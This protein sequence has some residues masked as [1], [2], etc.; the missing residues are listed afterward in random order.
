[1]KL[2]NNFLFINCLVVSVL[3]IFSVFS[4]YLLNVIGEDTVASMSIAVITILLIA[5]FIVLLRLSKNTD[6]SL[7]KLKQQ[8]DTVTA[9]A[10]AEDFD[11]SHKVSVS[12]F[13]EI[14]TLAQSFNHFTEI[15]EKKTQR[16]TALARES[17]LAQMGL[18]N[19][20][21]PALIVEDNGMVTYLNRSMFEFIQAHSENFQHYQGGF[22]NFPLTELCG[23]DETFVLSMME[24][25]DP[26]LKRVNQGELIINWHVTPVINEQNKIAIHIIEWTDLTEKI[27]IQEGF[28]AL[29]SAAKEGDFSQVMCLEDKTGF[30]FTMADGLNSIMQSVNGSLADVADVLH[31][32]AEGQ[33][34]KTIDTPYAGMLGELTSSM[35]EMVLHL[36]GIIGDIS[37]TVS[38]AKGGDFDCKIPEHD[39][40]GFY[41]SI[42]QAMNEQSQLI[43]SA[44]TDLSQVMFAI[45]EGDLSVQTNMPYQGKMKVLSD[46]VDAMVYRLRGVMGLMSNLVE[47][48]AHGNLDVRIPGMGQQGFYITIGDNLNKINDITQDAMDEITKALA[49]MSKGDLTYTMTK[50]YEGIFDDLKQDANKTIKNLVNVLLDIQQCS[51]GVKQAADELA[52]CNLNLNKRTEQQS[53][54]LQ[55]TAASMDKMTVTITQ[56]TA[57]SKLAN[58]L[59]NDTRQ[60]AEEGGLIVTQAI[61]AMGAISESSNKIA[62]IITVIDEIAF[63]TNLL[64]LNASVE[65]ARAGEQ[66][67]GFAVVAGEVRNLAGRSATAAKEIKDLIE[68]SVKKV[69]EGKDLVNKSGESLTNIVSAVN[70]VSE[71]VSVI[72]KASAEQSVGISEVNQAVINMDGATQQN[73]TLVEEIAST[74]SILGFQ[75]SD[76]VE[77]ISFFK[78]P[79]TGNIPGYEKELSAPLTDDSPAPDEDEWEAF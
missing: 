73:A 62:D 33:L 54:N 22:N 28:K 32:I 51:S 35:N 16:V 44:L 77:K 76:L 19:A 42:T 45:T 12:G 36:N 13:S 58:E 65:A 3:I 27:A 23:G 9:H 63:Q 34:T 11:F 39:K 17:T 7:Q 29:V 26:L 1:M 68:D 41:L 52:E 71:I 37:E 72:A 70:K 61:D 31:D 55:S 5:L 57:S 50:N 40:K 38:A 43:D 67:R 18:D 2:H 59:A 66:G 64:A 47:N 8:M 20:A 53:N 75:A 6:Q 24:M 56:N 30:Y 14:Q 21:T 15:F 78:T 46:Y 74:C 10:H 60:V 79:A 48:A 4:I 25:A 49:A 69:D